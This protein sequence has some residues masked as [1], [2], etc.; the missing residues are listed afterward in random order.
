M[1]EIGK[2]GKNINVI[3]NNMEKYMAFFLGKHLKFIDSLQFMNKSLES[4]AENLSLND[5]KYTLQEFQDEKLELMKRKGVYPYDYMD[6]FD[7]FNDKNL[8]SKKNFFFSILNDKHISNEEYE[9]AQSI[10]K[11][12]NL[13]TMGEYHDIYLK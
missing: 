3:P 11:I 1:Q 10:W 8:P 5:M 6:D 12:F 4:L 13:K 9:H 2:F 7:K